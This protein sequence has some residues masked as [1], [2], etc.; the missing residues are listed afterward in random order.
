MRKYIAQYCV[1]FFYRL[2]VEA[3]V[4]KLLFMAGGAVDVITL[5]QEA[6]R[7]DRQP[8]FK[9]LEAFLVPDL[10]LVLHTLGSYG[11]KSDQTENRA[12]H[13]SANQFKSLKSA[14][15]FL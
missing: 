10:I 11:H 7:A 13:F 1:A 6:L 15:E 8:A 14:E 4:G 9:A 3:L 12:L 2:A 5:S